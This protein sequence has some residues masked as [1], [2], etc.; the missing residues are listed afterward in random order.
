MA[1]GSK[2]SCI[3]ALIAESSMETLHL[4]VLHGTSRLDV[5]QFDLAILYAAQHAA[6]GEPRE[7]AVGWKIAT[8]LPGQV[9]C[10]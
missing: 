9:C 2:P 6:R 7:A 5:Y 10:C 3:Q 4:T 1:E 8:D